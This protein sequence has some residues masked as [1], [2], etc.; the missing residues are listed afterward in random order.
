MIEKNQNYIVD[1]ED[2]THE[3]AGVA[4]IDGFA[5]F[6]EGA[7]VGEKI[8]IKIVKVLK[9]FAYGKIEKIIEQSPE[10]RPPTCEIYKKCGGCKLQH[11]SYEAT[12]KFKKNVVKSNLKRIGKI[13]VEV[14]DTIGLDEPY[15]YRNKVQF[16]IGDNGNEIVVGFFAERTHEIVPVTDCSIQ[17]RIA[18]KIIIDMKNIIKRE[19]ISVYNE[20]TKKGLIRHIIIRNSEKT[21]EVMLIIVTN[22]EKFDKKDRMIDEITTR[23]PE[24]KSIIQNINTKVTNV[25]LGEKDI[26]LYGKDRITDY[27]G[28]LKFEISAHSF[29]QVNSKQTENLY[30]KALEYADLT[31]K[32]TVFDLYCGTGTISLFLAQKAK[33]VYGV[34]IVKQAVEDAKINAKNNNICNAE[35]IYGKSEEIAPQLYA[36][37]IRAD[38]V[39]IDP[40]RSGCDSKLIDMLN[41]MKPQKIVYVSCNSATLARDISL[42]EGYTVKKVQPVDMFSWS[43]HVETVVLM[44]KVF[45]GGV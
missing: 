21:N 2:M 45:N 31:G 28:K 12:L 6:V 43:F 36:K 34:E 23:N 15:A 9:N 19:K 10:R 11:M 14:L 16:P 3:G 22:G 37:G 25:I 24:I 18:N 8:R 29:F 27:I 4:R 30:N 39:V 13:D 38:V 17:S 7:I 33:K 32:E 40:P 26:L 1:I 41:K 35:F 5:V 42:F 20:T 44:E